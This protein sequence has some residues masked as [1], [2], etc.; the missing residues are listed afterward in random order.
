MLA[1]C[2]PHAH[3]FRLSAPA[4]IAA[5]IMLHTSDNVFSC[6]NEEQAD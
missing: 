5:Q 1:T 2:T 6:K 4:D 3:H